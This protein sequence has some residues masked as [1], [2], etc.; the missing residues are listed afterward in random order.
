MNHPPTGSAEPLMPQCPDLRYLGVTF[1]TEGT[2]RFTTKWLLI[3]RLSGIVP[4]LCNYKGSQKWKRE[5]KAGQSGDTL[6]GLTSLWLALK[7]GGGR[8]QGDK[9]ECANLEVGKSEE[10]AC[11]AYSKDSSQ[12]LSYF[13]VMH[14]IRVDALIITRWDLFYRW[15]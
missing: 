9:G 3:R 2:W 10:T 11:S 4:A 12:L 5:A 6:E 15:W 14:W 1:H 8:Q 7:T 13:Q